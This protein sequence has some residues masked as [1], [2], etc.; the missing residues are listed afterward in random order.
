LRLHGYAAPDGADFSLDLV[1]YKYFTPTEPGE[2]RPV[3]NLICAPSTVRFTLISPLAPFA[4]MK[5]REGD[6]NHATNKKG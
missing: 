3:Q 6:G 2:K 5:I 1:N 4:G